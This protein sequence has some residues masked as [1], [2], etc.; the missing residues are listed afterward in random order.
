MS[1]K[2]LLVSRMNNDFE[3]LVSLADYLNDKMHVEMF[4]VQD[5]E[6][7]VN[8][9][10][11]SILKSLGIRVFEYA[12]INRLHRLFLFFNQLA[13]TFSSSKIWRIGQFFRNIAHAQL[14]NKLYRYL[15]RID[16]DVV[17][18][19]NFPDTFRG[20]LIALK[21]ISSWCQERNRW[22]LCVAHGTAFVRKIGSKAKISEAHAYF[23]S[24]HLEVRHIERGELFFPVMQI[25]DLKLSKGFIQKCKPNLGPLI[26]K[27][28]VAFFLLPDMQ[29]NLEEH[30]FTQKFILKLIND[31]G[32]EA[33]ILK[34]HPNKASP[35]IDDDL[36][37]HPSVQLISTQYSSLEICHR[38]DI[39]ISPSS[40]IILEALA[41]QKPVYL[42]D[43][44]LNEEISE[45]YSELELPCFSFDEWL[46]IEN[47]SQI[48]FSY[49]VEAFN[50]IAYNSAPEGENREFVSK[51][52]LENCQNR[53]S[54]NASL[55][56]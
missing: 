38:A 48:K 6:R 36:L 8:P 41:L 47:I 43:Q 3:R 35:L 18:A 46:S 10:M 51:F 30:Q 34:G 54:S 45:I 53:P 5:L 31:S 40:S 12:D 21:Y 4:H 15:D 32:V 28:T 11:N 2:V 56:S 20:N 23:A 52:I 26:S 16:P 55:R 27:K 14:R 49:N 42:I 25:G 22:I 1:L 39:I 50:Q 44:L 24:N 13:R 19:T 9:L 17:I 29:Q 33:L 37:A 7:F